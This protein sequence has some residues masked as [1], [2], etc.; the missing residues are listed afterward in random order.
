MEGQGGG[1][2][3]LIVQRQRPCLPLLHITVFPFL[4]GVQAATES[5]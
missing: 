1:V 4:D 5:A 2:E 3:L